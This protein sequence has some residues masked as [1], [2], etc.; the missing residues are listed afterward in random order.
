METREKTKNR[1]SM[2]E[3]EGELKT[4]GGGSI[5][6]V[7]GDGVMAQA[8]GGARLMSSGHNLGEGNP[9][10]APKNLGNATTSHNDTS[11]GAMAEPRA[12]PSSAGDGGARRGFDLDVL[13]ACHAGQHK[14]G[15]INN[16]EDDA[17]GEWQPTGDVNGVGETGR[18]GDAGGGSG[19]MGDAGGG[20]GAMVDVGGDSDTLGNIGKRASKFSGVFGSLGN[21]G[22]LPGSDSDEQSLGVITGGCPG[23]LVE[24]MEILGES[25]VD[26]GGLGDSGDFDGSLRLGGSL[27]SRPGVGRVD[28]C[29]RETD[30]GI[31]TP[32]REVDGP[33]CGVDRGAR[34]S[35]GDTV[36]VR[37]ASR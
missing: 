8:L 33:S 20:L 13:A 28:T 29:I 26:S 30:L 22:K 37:Q 34:A 5:G 35:R 12:M 32:L 3:K 6:S 36:D 23:A 11:G 25:V 24:A 17:H 16:R 1:V 10:V 9:Y 19:A 2:K 27:C 7:V 14:G 18:E 31:E 4:S 21:A 15:A